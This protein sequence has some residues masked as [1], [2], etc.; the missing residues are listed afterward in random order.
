[1]LEKRPELN[2]EKNIFVSISIVDD[3]KIQELNKKYFRRDFPTD[4]LSFNIDQ[5][6][7]SGEYFLGDIVVNKEQAERQA[8]EYGNS[9]EEELSELVAHGMLHL[10]GVHHPEDDE[11][12]VHG[13][14][15]KH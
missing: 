14:V 11:H 8:S 15:S 6:E 13:V 1:M 9:T 10:L 7:A 2:S 4:V 3:K 5:K 12:G